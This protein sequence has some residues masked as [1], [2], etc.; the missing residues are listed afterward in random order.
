MNAR[1]RLI[2]TALA[3]SGILP[4]WFLALAPETLFGLNTASLFVSYG[5]IINAF[6][7]G[8]LWGRAQG[9][10]KDNSRTITLLVASNVLALISFA[11]LAIDL[12]AAALITQ[13]IV[14]GIL[15][16]ADY[17]IY[18]GDLERRW[19]WKLRL[20]VTL[21]VS[22]GYDVLLLKYVLGASS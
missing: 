20:T 15:L 13:V 21:L 9:R 6:L 19:Y 22:L 8:G 2:S 14:F 17:G 3:L 4:F 12:P 11:T 16:V 10:S 7:A 1:P 18:A 5:A